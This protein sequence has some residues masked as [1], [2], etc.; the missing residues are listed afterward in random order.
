MSDTLIRIWSDY[1]D[2]SENLF[3]H[4]DNGSFSLPPEHPVG[5]KLWD[6]PGREQW[7][8]TVYSS[9]ELE[10]VVDQISSSSLT[11]DYR[12]TCTPWLNELRASLFSDAYLVEKWLA[13]ERKWKSEVNTVADL[14]MSIF[15]FAA[16]AQY[17]DIARAAEF[18]LA[19][20]W[21]KGEPT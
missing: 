1:K 17:S 6:T 16:G 5:R 7:R 15:M 9:D 4:W 11:H 18:L 20:G 2:D 12:I 13:A 19:N 14:A 21:R 8:I 3:V 10:W